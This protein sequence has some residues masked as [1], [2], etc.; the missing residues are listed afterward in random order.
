[1]QIGAFFLV[2][3]NIILFDD[4]SWMQL[5]PLTFARPAGEL[6]L[7]IC[8]IKD[9]WIELLGGQVSYIT[10]DHLALSYPL[11]IEEDN[12]LINGSVIPSHSLASLIDQLAVNEALMDENTLIAARFPKHQFDLL[13][14]NKSIEELKGFQLKET[15]Y[16]KLNFP[17]DIITHQATIIDL[18]IK[19][20]AQEDQKIKASNSIQIVGPHPL[21]C[22]DGCK[23]SNAIINTE[24][25]PVYFGKNTLI[26]EGTLIRGPFA[27]GNNGVVKMGAKIYGPASTGPGCVLGG[28]IKMSQF[29]DHSNKGHDGYLGNSVVGSFCNLGAGTSVSNLKNNLSTISS[30]NYTNKEYEDT[31]N[32]YLGAIIGDHVRTGINV[33]LNTG[34]TVGFSCNLYGSGFFPKYVPSFSWGSPSHLEPFILN[35]ALEVAARAAQMKK[36]TFN[37]GDQ[38]IF[39]EVFTFTKKFRK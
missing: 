16:H 35:Q 4:D 7:G 18:D 8:S 2:M 28:E 13:M 1:M 21:Y 29:M 6:I 17:W 31:G 22:A 15:P 9:K 5:L 20:F 19:L 27:L 11:I 14:E 12:F 32:N 37:P 23:L 25:G 39:K 10:Q 34:T 24:K 33:Q 38:E 26:M 30:W 36:T 3:K